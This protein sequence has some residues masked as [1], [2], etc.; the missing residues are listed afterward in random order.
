MRSV[1]DYI[2]IL[3]KGKIVEEGSAEE[4]FSLPKNNYTKELLTV[5]I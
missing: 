3:Q 1:S 2:I 5:V 4:V